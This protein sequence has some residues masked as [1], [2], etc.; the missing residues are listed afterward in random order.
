MN[1]CFFRDKANGLIYVISFAI[2]AL[3][4]LTFGWFLMLLF[5][6]SR[7]RSF[8]RGIAK[9]PSLHFQTLWFP[10]GLAGL[11]VSFYLLYVSKYGFLA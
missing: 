1:K 10:G 2:G 6:V 7:A 3:I 9:L 8:S 11:L 5:F 4:V